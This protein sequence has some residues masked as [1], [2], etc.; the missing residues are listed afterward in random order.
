MSNPVEKL[1]SEL[2]LVIFS[3]LRRSDLPFCCRTCKKWNQIANDKELWQKIAAGINK[4]WVFR[5]SDG[6]MVESLGSMLGRRITKL[7]G[8]GYT[9]EQIKW[10]FDIEYRR[11][12][13]RLVSSWII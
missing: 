10:Q 3:Y 9:N 1:P 4:E 8:E 7:K 6:L 2:N 5:K 12:K 13:G 11:M